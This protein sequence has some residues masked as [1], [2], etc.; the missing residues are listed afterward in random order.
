MTIKEFEKIMISAYKVI[1]AKMGLNRHIPAV[2]RYAPTFLG[3]LGLPHI[4]DMQGIAKI[5]DVL[6]H[7]G[8]G[9]I[10]GKMIEAQLEVCHLH[11]GVGDNIFTADSRAISCGLYFLFT[12]MLF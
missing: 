1:L 3:G 10:V 11:V 9:T 5:K 7:C 4:F 6:Y 2:F 8:K 12:I